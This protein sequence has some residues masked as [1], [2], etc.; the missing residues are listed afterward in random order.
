MIIQKEN[1]PYL[2]FSQSGED[3]FAWV[4]LAKENGFFV[5]VGAHHPM[6][7][8][9][10]FSLYLRG[11]SGINIEPNPEP[12]DSFRQLRPGD[13]TINLGVSKESKVMDYYSFNLSAGNTFLPEIAEN[14]LK[15]DL[16]VHSNQAPQKIQTRPLRDILDE[17]YPQNRYFDLLS[18][19][20]E[21]M[22][23]EVLE[24]SNWKKYRPELVMVEDHNFDMENPQK[25]LTFQ[26]MKRQGYSLIS[27]LMF[28]LIFHETAAL[29]SRP[30]FYGKQKPSYL[31]P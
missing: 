18:I 15:N 13:L 11:W 8:S 25:S 7:Y 10:T 9:T 23:L 17:H 3:L 22:D 14:T 30:R 26:F 27:K 4:Y 28:T 16:R 29:K 6:E 24:S 21:G 5:D 19:D 20:V 31:K 2:Y 1:I 12:M